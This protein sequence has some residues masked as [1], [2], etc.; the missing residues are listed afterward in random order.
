MKKT[1][2]LIFICCLPICFYG[3]AEK[4]TKKQNVICEVTY[5]SNET[6][7]DKESKGLCFNA[8]LGQGQLY[9]YEGADLYLIQGTDTLSVQKSDFEGEAFFKKVKPGDYIVIAKKEG[10]SQDKSKVVVKDKS[11]LVK[12]VLFPV[13]KK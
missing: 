10:F 11:A 9:A 6:L 7:P 2:L 5:F 3:Q 1:L 12:L 13:I 8:V 4:K